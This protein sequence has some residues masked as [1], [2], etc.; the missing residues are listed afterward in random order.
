[1]AV[2]EASQHIVCPTY[3]SSDPV[4]EEVFGAM[5]D[6]Y[7]HELGA[8]LP[9]N[10]GVFWTGS[11]VISTHYSADDL[12]PVADMLC[13]KPIIWDNY[14]VNDGRLTSNHLHLQ[15]FTG[16]PSQMAQWCEGHL[17]NP[18]SQPM[19]SQLPLQS[20]QAVYQQQAA[21]NPALALEQSLLSLAHNDLASQLAG[22]IDSFQ[23]AGLSTL[24]QQQR[25]EKSRLYQAFDHPVADE[26]VDWLNGG[27][28]FDPECLTG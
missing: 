28:L 11:K 26:V 4:L 21:Y 12:L 19:L 16:R 14:P 9:S 17:V 23:V 20:L 13:R 10:I 6:N 22:D 1:M 24:T 8:G 18:M 5:P 15:S 7:L 3:Y 27:Y 25:Q 2:S